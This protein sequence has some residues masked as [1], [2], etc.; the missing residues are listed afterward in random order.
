MSSKPLNLQIQVS[1]G[2]FSY[3]YRRGNP[4]WHTAYMSVLG[5]GDKVCRNQEIF[6]WS[7]PLGVEISLVLLPLLL[8]C[9]LCLVITELQAERLDCSVWRVMAEHESTWVEIAHPNIFLFR[10]IFCT[11]PTHNHAYL[12]FP[13]SHIGCKETSAAWPVGRGEE[14]GCWG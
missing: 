9:Y 1:K 13:V 11:S 5:G 6:Q 12:L 10:L 3:S 14:Q 4:I 8:L 7:L 2:G